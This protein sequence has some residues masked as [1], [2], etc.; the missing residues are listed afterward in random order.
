MGIQARGHKMVLDLCL[1]KTINLLVIPHWL[2]LKDKNNRFC[3]RLA[4]RPDRNQKRVIVISCGSAMV[5]NLI[6]D[7]THSCWG[8]SAAS[9]WSSLGKAF[10]YESRL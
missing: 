7:F 1:H 8:R 4:P 3:Y 6:S 5:L 9:F 10:F 2:E